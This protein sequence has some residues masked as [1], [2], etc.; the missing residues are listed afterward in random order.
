MSSSTETS[1]GGI[2][3]WY[4]GFMVA[5]A[6]ATLS[7]EI[8]QATRLGLLMLEAEKKLIEYVL[9]HVRVYVIDVSWNTFIAYRPGGP[10][11]TIIITPSCSG[12]YAV[13]AFLA[14]SL[15]LPFID[16]RRKLYALLVYAPIVLLANIVRIVTS[17]A[18][19]MA[20][21]PSL[22]GLVHNIL[23]SAAIILL[24]SVLWL[25]WLYRSLRYRSSRLGRL[26]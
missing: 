12:I 26:R 21:G 22:F 16:A 20:F 2:R 7:I 23:G 24:Y 13:V 3:H 6:S 4:L 17:I 9:L 5:L 14:L 25:D 8:L 19:A 11:L 10:V 18:L 1:G 15:S